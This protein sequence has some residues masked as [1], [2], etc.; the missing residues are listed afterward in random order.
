MGLEELGEYQNRPEVVYDFMS[1]YGVPQSGNHY[2]FQNYVTCS[3]RYC[4]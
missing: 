2:F 1:I 4:D 3:S